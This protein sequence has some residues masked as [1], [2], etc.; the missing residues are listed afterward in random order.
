[1]SVLV[2]R[3]CGEPIEPAVWR[4]AIWYHV[5][6]DEVACRKRW[7]RPRTKAAPR[8]TKDQSILLREK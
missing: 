6:N 7:F 1:M 5:H 2:C 4:K 8:E 3:N